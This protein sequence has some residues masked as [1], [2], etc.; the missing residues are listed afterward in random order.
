MILTRRQF[1]KLWNEKKPKLGKFN[2]PLWIPETMGDT[3]VK[4]QWFTCV[5][6]IFYNGGS[7]KKKYWAWCNKNM[8]GSV[9]CFSSTGRE[10]EVQ[11]E[12]WGFTRKDDIMFWMLRWA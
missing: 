12:W 4:C 1:A 3:P 5:R 8:Q 9:L 6:P 11:E 7:E 10:T 2:G